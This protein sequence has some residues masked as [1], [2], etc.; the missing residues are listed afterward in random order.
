MAGQLDAAIAGCDAALRI[1][2][3][4]ACSPFGRGMARRRRGEQAGGDA[5]IA[6]ARAIR[7]GIAEEMARYGVR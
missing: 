4:K 1:D 7:A 3:R 2:P 5:D 6:A